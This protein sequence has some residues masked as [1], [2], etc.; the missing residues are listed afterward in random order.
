MDGKNPLNKEQQKLNLLGHLRGNLGLYLTFIFAIVFL[1]MRN[2]ALKLLMEHDQILTIHYDGA[3][4]FCN[5]LFVGNLCVGFITLSFFGPLSLGREIRAL[6]LRSSALLILT[7][8]I[9]ATSLSLLFF[10]LERTTVVQVI[11]ISQLKGIFYLILSYIILRVAFKKNE[12]LGYGIIF[13]AITILILNENILFSAVTWLLIAGVCLEKLSDVIDKILLKNQTEGIILS[14]NSFIGAIF[15]FIIFT[16][17]YGPMHFA[18]AFEGKL[19]VL[20]VFYA[21][22]TI[23]L[24]GIL[25]L[26]ATKS[27]TPQLVANFIM[28]RPF[29]TVL[30]AFLLVGEIPNQIE[31]II[32]A[33]IVSGLLV[34]KFKGKPRSVPMARVSEISPGKF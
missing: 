30:M 31:A 11:L 23:G 16:Y 14:S 32:F 28:L 15:Y 26:K 17:L 8:V 7:S 27:G 1:S 24:G 33:V 29:S 18:D 34:I 5:V 13:T 12:L 6:N 2:P 20:M 25:W 9:R 4:S 22:I 21:G 10:A 19:W 3:I